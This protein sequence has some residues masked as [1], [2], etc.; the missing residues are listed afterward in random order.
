METVEDIKEILVDSSSLISFLRSNTDSKG[1]LKKISLGI[2]RGYLSSITLF[3][4][5]VGCFRSNNPT[6]EIEKV[7]KIKSWFEIVD[8]SDQISF[9]AAKIISNLEKLGKPIE[10]KDLLICACAVSKNIHLLTEN[11]KHFQNI[12]NIKLI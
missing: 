7:N 11:K 12:H 9:E 5:Y 1:V 3:E 10:I 2:I 6:L 8:I 4:L